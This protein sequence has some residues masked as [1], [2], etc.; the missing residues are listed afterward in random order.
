MRQIV[1]DR[2]RQ[3]V[4]DGLRQIV[5]DRLRQT[6]YDRLRQIV[7][8]IISIMHV[9]GVMMN[10]FDCSQHHLIKFI[11]N[12]TKHCWKKHQELDLM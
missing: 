2:L 3:I 10:D 5:H 9:L 4:H 6:V 12:N 8:R 11:L 7:P 1:H